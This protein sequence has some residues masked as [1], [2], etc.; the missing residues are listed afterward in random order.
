MSESFGFST[1]A[2]RILDRVYARLATRARGATGFVSAPE[3][4]TI[5]SFARGRQLVAG[6][7]LFAGHLIEAPQVDLWDVRAPDAAFE[8]ELHGFS[9]LDDL[10]AVGD[11]STRDTAQQWVWGWIDRYGR[12][13]AQD[14]R[15]T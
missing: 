2:A 3:P 8:A 4:R 10:A 9:W 7:Y 14:G 5:G 15:P 6:N 1:R 12:G 13:G 11:V